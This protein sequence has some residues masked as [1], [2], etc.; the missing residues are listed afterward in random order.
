MHAKVRLTLYTNLLFFSRFFKTNMTVIDVFFVNIFVFI[1]NKETKK[2]ADLTKNFNHRTFISWSID[3]IH[4][5]SHNKMLGLQF[6]HK[7]K[8]YDYNFSINGCC[9]VTTSPKQQ[10]GSILRIL[11]FFVRPLKLL[12]LQGNS[13]KVFL[14]E[15]AKMEAFFSK[16]WYS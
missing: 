10:R 14:S 15:L 9:M 12:K 13:L 7:W 1:R 11:V 3:F 4:S 6:C 8:F 2:L 5:K 16:K